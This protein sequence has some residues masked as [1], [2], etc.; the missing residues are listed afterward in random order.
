MELNLRMEAMRGPLRS[1]EYGSISVGQ[2]K[3]K[4]F[5]GKIKSSAEEEDGEEGKKKERSRDKKRGN[6][7][8]FMAQDD[9]DHLVMAGLFKTYVFI[10]YKIFWGLMCIYFDRTAEELDKKWEEREGMTCSKCNF[11][12]HKTLLEFHRKKALQSCPKQLK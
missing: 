9:H 7:K 4:A 1:S 5:S 3:Q 10:Y 8:S 11:L 6:S 12:V 2:P